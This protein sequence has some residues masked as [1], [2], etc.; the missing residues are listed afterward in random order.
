MAKKEKRVDVPNQGHRH[1][2]GSTE[3]SDF[4]LNMDFDGA[5]RMCSRFIM[6][7]IAIVTLVLI[8]AYYTQKVEMYVEDEIPHYLS[9]NFIFY[10]ASMVMLTGGVGYLVFNVARKK[11][12]VDLKG[13]R[14]LILPV[15]VMLTTLISSLA[16]VS[17]HDSIL[18]Y[19]GRHDGFLMTFGCFGLF[20]VAAALGDKD[21]KKKLGDV[22]VGAGVF[23]SLVGILEAIPATA[24][25]FS[26]YF[27]RLF[28][29]LGTEASVNTAAGEFYVSTEENL[30]SPGIYTDGKVAS[31]YLTSPHALAVVITIAFA[32][33]LAGAAFDESKKRRICYIIAAPVMAAA[34]CLAEVWSGV[35][36][37]AAAALFVTVF[38]VIKAA[39]GSKGALA[40]LLP[41]A[42]SGVIAG[43]LF[44]TGTA[45]FRDENIIF[46]DSFA[47]NK[48]MGN[49]TRYDYMYGYTDQKTDTRNIYDYLFGDAENVISSK[50]VLGL[51][52]DNAAYYIDDY[53][54]SVD[55]SYNEFMDT[56][57]QK[58]IITL[59]AYGF[60]LL[61][62]VIK[63][64]KLLAAFIKGE[65]DWMSAAALAAVLAYM[66]QAW[67]NTT[68]FSATYLFYIAAGL[69]WDISVKG[70]ETKSLLKNKK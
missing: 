45:Y 62:T 63:G 49:Y 2:F 31:G 32:I 7:A 55:R 17:I 5:Q 35:I 64:F 14:L 50:P 52:P 23:Q 39:K 40:V 37:I 57:M 53:S 58:G 69:C 42:L 65:G 13:N 44:G 68:W 4:I 3:K 54:L 27:D 66:A 51:G 48:S 60:F 8:P 10:A 21:N 61:V 1:L 43:V 33:A 6:L 12:L 16:A 47:N 70:R 38:A 18:G 15:I 25:G 26:N 41:V 59:V 34:A 20:A 9:D 11:G 19:I 29:R 67:F 56:A 30:L 22:L 36:C 28:L 46:T 24:G